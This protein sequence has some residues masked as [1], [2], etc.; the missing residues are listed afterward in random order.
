MWADDIHA[1][2]AEMANANA[3]IRSAESVLYALTG[4]SSGDGRVPASKRGAYERALADL[5]DGTE[6]RSAANH[7]RLRL[8]SKLH[9]R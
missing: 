6:A 9:L 5:A 7:R 1:V 4:S 3:K 8:L 2:E